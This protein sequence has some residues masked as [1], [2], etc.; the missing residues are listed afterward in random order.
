LVSEKYKGKIKFRIN[1]RPPRYHTHTHNPAEEEDFSLYEFGESDGGDD[2]EDP[3][4]S[5]ISGR[6]S[7]LSPDGSWRYEW[8]VEEK[9]TAAM[10]WT[11]GLNKRIIDLN[12]TIVVLEHLNELGHTELNWLLARCLC[13]RGRGRV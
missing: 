2:G 11:Y 3:L 9:R 8:S 10:E 1:I 4:E 5:V 12:N 7:S 13:N 6:P